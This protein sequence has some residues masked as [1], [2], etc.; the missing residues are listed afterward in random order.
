[1]NSNHRPIPG[2]VLLGGGTAN[3][4]CGVVFEVNTAGAETILLT[5]RAPPGPIRGRA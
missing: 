4:C 5:F 1:M 2:L 3:G